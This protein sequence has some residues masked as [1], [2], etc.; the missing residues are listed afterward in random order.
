MYNAFAYAGANE[1]VSAQP[2]MLKN[3]NEMFY[4]VFIVK[5]IYKLLI[6]FLHE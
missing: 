3:H 5:R 4:S 1:E 6:L 2:T